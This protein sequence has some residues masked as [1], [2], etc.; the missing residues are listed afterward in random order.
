MERLDVFNCSNVLIASYFA[1]DKGC[2]HENSDHTLIYIVSGELEINENGK[3]TVLYAGNCAFMRRDNRMLLQK[4]VR[5]NIP[6]RSVVLKFTRSFLREFYNTLDKKNIPMDSKRTKESLV[7]LPNNRPD[8]RSLF[9]SVM[10]YFDSDIKPSEDILKLKMTEGLF[11]LLNT[12]INLYA[13]LFD[14][15]DPWKIDIL[16]YLNKNYMCDMSM[17]E[18][19]RFTGRSI[20]TFK[21]DFA[22][23]S[24]L[25]PQKWIIQKRLSEAHKLIQRGNMKITD[26]CYDVGFKN[27]SHFS[28]IYKEAYG[29]APS[30]I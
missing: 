4:H 7:L 22:K 28:K 1:D 29:Y 5:N 13:S 19:A 17:E 26:I 6:Y 10:P 3:K 27:L 23:I 12:D 2:A 18:I 24:H 25:T 21:R 11:V 8:I 15:V 30:V 14:F 20:S 9:E 16:D